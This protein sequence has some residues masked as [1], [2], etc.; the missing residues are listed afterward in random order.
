M[1]TRHCALRLIICVSYHIREF[2]YIV[3]ICGPGSPP[4]DQFIVLILLV[5]AACLVC[6][7]V[8][9]SSTDCEVVT[10][11]FLHLINALI[12]GILASVNKPGKS[13]ASI[14]SNC[15]IRSH[16]VFIVD[17]VAVAHR[18]TCNS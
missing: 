9:P 13:I 3:G 18:P 7:G 12:I 8:P 14:V 5:A 2:T 6:P 15:R 16:P 17:C 10:L 11:I 1:H 4:P